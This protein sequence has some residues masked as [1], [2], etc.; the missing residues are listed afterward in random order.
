MSLNRW[1]FDWR[2]QVRMLSHSRMSAGRQFQV[3]GTGTEKARRASSVL[4]GCRHGFTL[5]RVVVLFSYG[6]VLE[7]VVLYKFIIQLY[8]DHTGRP[9]PIEDHARAHTLHNMQCTEYN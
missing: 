1:V 5:L 9:T 4:S 6:S 3:D 7:A 2:L 8:T